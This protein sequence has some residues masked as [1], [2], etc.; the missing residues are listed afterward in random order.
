MDLK[1]LHSG[2]PHHTIHLANAAEVGRFGEA[3][4][5]RHLLDQ[6]Y[7]LL[8]RNWYGHGEVRGELD[9]VVSQRDTVC[10]VE[11]KTR[12]TALM[13]HPAEAVTSRKVD[14][15]ARLARAWLVERPIRARAT[16]L[17]VISVKVRF[18]PGTRDLAAARLDHMQGVS[19]WR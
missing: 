12:S 8:D 4:A 5:V 9:I 10:F 2:P 7:T 15:L 16:R 13:A 11:V 19:A 1:H 6:G 14:S 3:L 17:D 18:N